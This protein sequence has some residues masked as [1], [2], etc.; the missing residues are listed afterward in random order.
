MRLLLPFMLALLSSACSNVHFSSNIDKEN[1]DTYFAPSSVTVYQK[2]DLD[3]LDY[4]VLGAVEGSSCQ[5]NENAVPADAR[6]ARTKARINAANLNANGIV[7][8]SCLS[9]KE[10]KACISNVICYGR[11]LKVSIDE[12]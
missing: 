6:E 12:K 1:F 9:F 2:A 5:I 11:A 8:Q 10:D 3:D 4:Q 7:F